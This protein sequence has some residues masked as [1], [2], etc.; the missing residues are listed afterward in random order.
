MRGYL[1]IVPVAARGST[2]LYVR[3]DT[4]DRVGSPLSGPGVQETGCGTR[5]SAPRMGRATWIGSFLPGRSEAWR[6]PS[7][8]R[9]WVK[10]PRS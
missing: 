10:P 5:L 9:A 8:F 2:G 6:S 7:H 1:A 3:C 4:G